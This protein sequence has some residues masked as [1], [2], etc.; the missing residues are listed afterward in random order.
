MLLYKYPYKLSEYYLDNLNE[1][2]ISHYEGYYVNFQQIIM[3]V[4]SLLLV[5]IRMILEVVLQY[6]A[7]R[8]LYLKM[9][10]GIVNV[11]VSVCVCVLMYTCLSVYG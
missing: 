8:F 1:Y 6:L 3:S 4:N 2:N 5:N 7:T 10:Y 11:F 9:F